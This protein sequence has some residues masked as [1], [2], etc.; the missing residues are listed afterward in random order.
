MNP[1]KT[2][3]T[4]DPHL[5]HELVLWKLK[6]PFS[7]VKDMDRGIVTVWNALVPEDADVYILGDISFY[8][9]LEDTISVLRQLHGRLHLVWGNH[10]RKLLKKEEFRSCFHTIFTERIVDLRIDGAKIV[11]C[12]F[13]LESWEGMS[14]GTWHLHGHSHGHMRKFGRRYDVGMDS[15][16]CAPVSF[17]E[18]QAIMAKRPIM[19]REHYKGPIWNAVGSILN[20]LYSLSILRARQ[21]VKMKPLGPSASMENGASATNAPSMN[22]S[23]E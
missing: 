1:D 11:L 7:D 22:S 4:S 12:H 21:T 18:L 20:W 9:A 3:F 8:K 19:S 23:N 14:H 13:P 15:N 6:R 2:F 5:G 17:R 10:D 16:G